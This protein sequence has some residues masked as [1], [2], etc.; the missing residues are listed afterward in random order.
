MNEC[1]CP[2]GENNNFKER[3]A[4]KFNFQRKVFLP[5]PV[6]CPRTRS[7]Y[8][9][10]QGLTPIGDFP[11]KGHASQ[12]ENI[13]F[14][15]THCIFRRHF[16]VCMACMARLSR[17]KPLSGVILL[18]ICFLLF[19]PTQRHHCHATVSSSG[20]HL[21]GYVKFFGD[22]DQL[23]D[24]APLLSLMANNYAK[25]PSLWTVLHQEA[26]KGGIPLLTGKERQWTEER[27]VNKKVIS[28][29]HQQNQ[30]PVGTIKHRVEKLPEKR[31]KTEDR[32]ED[33]LEKNTA[34]D[35]SKQRSKRL[36]CGKPLKEKIMEL[37]RE[38]KKGDSSLRSN[39]RNFFKS[40]TYDG[41][42]F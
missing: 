29:I 23:A 41:I 20:Q 19:F 38:V 42:R 31:D 13:N 37:Q 28:W 18:V 21:T 12:L 7:A 5:S 32:L 33:G 22:S 4:L 2:F 14:S 17:C 35:A 9:P 40:C 24:Y 1:K 30:Q 26:G 6:E 15:H 8:L 39:L 36:N 16:S 25:E 34:R 3:I 10:F 11:M 27:V